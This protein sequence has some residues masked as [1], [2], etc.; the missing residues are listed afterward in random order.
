VLAVQPVLIPESSEVGSIATQHYYSVAMP[1]L[2]Q[3]K[4][5]GGYEQLATIQSP[6]ITWLLI[7]SSYHCGPSPLT[8][9]STKGGFYDLIMIER[10]AFS[11]YPT[12]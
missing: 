12:S 7:C 8:W 9:R 10:V 1:N 3:Y 11:K 5:S 2:S 6:E 4:L